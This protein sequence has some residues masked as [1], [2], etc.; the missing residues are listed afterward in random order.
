MKGR[1]RSIRRKP[2]RRRFLC[3]TASA[4]GSAFTTPP[5]TNTWPWCTATPPTT[6]SRWHPTNSSEKRSSGRSRG[7]R[8]RAGSPG[9]S[10]RISP[11]GLAT[12]SIPERLRPVAPALRQ[13]RPRAG[14]RSALASDCAGH[15]LAA[16]ARLAGDVIHT[17]LHE[18][19]RVLR[20][21]LAELGHLFELGLIV[22][23]RRLEELGVDAV[24]VLHRLAAG[25]VLRHRQLFLQTA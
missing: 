15:A 5:R 12:S 14:E 16:V 1:R 23:N 8:A 11:A 20:Q 21:R 6:S 13:P 18:L 19:R 25:Q 9:S 2:S 4:C 7:A 3:Q 24:H 22:G 17:R 10:S